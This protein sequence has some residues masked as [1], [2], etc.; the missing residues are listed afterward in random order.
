[1]AGATLAADGGLSDITNLLS[2]VKDQ[3][4]STS[5]STDISQAGVTQQI[6]DILQS[7]TGLAAVAGAQKSAGLYNGSTNTLLTND[8]LAR[9]S[10]QVA[11]KNA[12]QTTSSTKKASVTKQNIESLLA[13]QALKSA[14]GSDT[15]KAGA[16][17]VYGSIADELGIAT[18]ANDTATANALSSVSSAGP[19]SQVGDF[20]SLESSIAS[21]GDD[22]GV[23][24]LANGTFADG[25]DAGIG[26]LTSADLTDGAGSAVA[27]GVGADTADVAGL[28]TLDD[29]AA[30]SDAADAGL[31]E[32]GSSGSSGLAATG[33]GALAVAS[34]ADAADTVNSGDKNAEIGSIVGG[35]GTG[36]IIR[37]LDS[38]SPLDSVNPLGQGIVKGIGDAVGIDTTKGWIVCTELLRQGKFNKRHY[39]AGLKVFQAYPQHLLCGYYVWASPLVLY[40][41]R[42]PSSWITCICKHLF[43]QRAEFLAARAGV[44]GARDTVYGQSISTLMFGFCWILGQALNWVGK[45]EVLYGRT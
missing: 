15:V 20:T 23:G 31:G 19:G 45:K 33:W 26:A 30:T 9:A 24:A 40:I 18:G 27:G 41:R 43:G 11:A 42:N 1:M 37:G 21:S 38:G 28:E 13:T 16:K 6:N 4:S 3:K 36:D 29:A 22:L 39:A 17:S 8:L 5:T 7:N 34:A 2:L 32:L 10:A 25:A 12:T 14:I 44:F 35:L